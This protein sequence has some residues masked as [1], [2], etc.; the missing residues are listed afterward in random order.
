M[1]TQDAAQQTAAKH[2]NGAGHAPLKNRTEPKS[3]CTKSACPKPQPGA[4]AGGCA[5]DGAQIALLPVADAAHIVHGPIACAGSSWDNRG[6]RSSGPTLWRIGMTTDLDEQ[7]LIMG[8]G[9]SRLH[10]AIGQAV[11]SYQPAAVFVYTTCV[12]A[13]TGQDIDTVCRAATRDYHLPVIP[14]DCAGFYGAKNYGNRIAGATLLDHVIGTRE[15][16]P[17]P[18]QARR[19]DIQVHDIGM[20]GEFNIAGELWNVIPLFDELGLR[21]LAN[22]SGDSRFHELQTLHRSQ[23]NMVVCSKAM[24]NVAERLKQDYAIDYFEGSFYGVEDTST[25]LRD[26][27]RLLGDSDLV[28]RTEELIGREEA[29]IRQQLA[30]WR[31]RLE[32]K[33]A[34]L[35]TG[36]VKSWSI[37]SALHDLGMEVVAT[38]TRKSTE[39]DK[40]RVR[41]IMGEQTRMLDSGG[42]QTLIDTV[43]RHNA[44][45]LIAG[46]RNMYT[47]L[48]ARIPF[49]DINQERPYGY[50][51]YTGMVELARQLSLTIDSPIWPQVRTPAPWANADANLTTFD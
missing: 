49:L 27:A 43:K 42:P 1:P 23:A 4:A 6:T 20:I 47:A 21:L 12:P 15:P 37:V 51:G 2:G 29:R 40:E 34:L 13:L 48:K 14:V 30:P 38:G 35:Y 17:I 28:R 5:F 32:G 26:F 7:S 22:I 36:G 9:E 33:R 11:Y 39:A 25:A 45:V 18:E 50:A 44:D 10:E 24:M 3:G 8:K 19:K 41:K 31:E 16:D 46:G